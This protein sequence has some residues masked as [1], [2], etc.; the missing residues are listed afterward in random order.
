M[1]MTRTQVARKAQ[2]SP[3]TEKRGHHPPTQAQQ[4]PALH[5]HSDRAFL[6]RSTLCGDF[7]A[8]IE[9]QGPGRLEEGQPKPPTRPPPGRSGQPRTPQR[10][11][12]IPRHLTVRTVKVFQRRTG[13]IG[14][15]KGG[16]FGS[17]YQLITPMPSRKPWYDRTLQSCHS[18]L[19]LP[20]IGKQP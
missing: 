2:P 9:V 3:P 20:A 7:N 15:G 5:S 11:T 14:R 17:F 6:P 13:M 16:K 1:S 10:V 19:C 4:N 18:Y 8:K 12:S